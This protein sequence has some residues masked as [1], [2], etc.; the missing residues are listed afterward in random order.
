MIGTILVAHG[1]CSR[2]RAGSTPS[3]THSLG[4]EITQEQ[5]VY[6]F[7]F[8]PWYLSE[9]ADP[10]GPP[11]RDRLTLGEKLG[12]AKQL[13]FDAMQFHDDDAVPELESLG[14]VQIAA[15]ARAMKRQLADHGLVVEFVAPRLWEIPRTI[16]GAYTSN[17]PSERAHAMERAI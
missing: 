11:V 4:G 16:D 3:A 15:E 7:S 2:R 12:I 5:L 17:D 10:F 1:R 14:P 6:R 13:G 9:G 8:G